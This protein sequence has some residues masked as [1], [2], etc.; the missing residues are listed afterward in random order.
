MD[1]GTLS[2][3]PK[4]GLRTQ[5]SRKLIIAKSPTNDSV[6]TQIDIKKELH[7]AIFRADVK[8][9]EHLFQIGGS[10]NTQID[11]SNQT[12]LH[13]ACYAGH[14]DVVQFL[15]QQ[16]NVNIDLQDQH[17]WTPLLCAASCGQVD[18]CL[19]LLQKG[20]NPQISNDQ[21]TTVLHYL[22]RKDLSNID[23][24]LD[25]NN[26]NPGSNPTTA[27]GNKYFLLMDTILKKGLDINVQNVFGETP[28][29]QAAAR[30]NV[31]A[32]KFLLEHRAKWNILTSKGETAL[33]YAE[34]AGFDDIVKLIQAEQE[35]KKK[36]S[37]VTHANIR[38]D[39]MADIMSIMKDKESGVLVK[40][41]QHFFVF[42]QDSFQG[43]DMVD[44]V[45][46]NLPIRTREEAV[47]YGQKLL[48]NHWIASVTRKKKFKDSKNLYQFSSGEAVPDEPK[49]EKVS[50]DDFEQVKVIGKGGFGKV[51]LARKIETGKIYAIKLMDKAKILN[52][53]RDFKN[54]MSEKRILQND[55]CFLVHLHYAFQNE[56]DFVLVMDFIGG[57]DLY[58][59][60][61]RL[62]RFPEKVVQ[63]IIAEL[64][65][66][67][68]YLHSC[69]IIYRDLKPQNILLDLDGHICLADFGLSKEVLQNADTALHTACG[70]PTYSAPE[71]LDGSPYK[72]TIDYWSLGIV[73]YQ[74]LVGKPPFEFDGDFAKLLNSIYS[75]EIY[76]PRP[77]ISENAQ[78]LLQ[79]F[80]QRDPH[81]R[82]DDPDIIK[83]HPFFRGIEW[84]KLEVKK[85]PS[86]I[87]FTLSDSDVSKNF[88]PKYTKMPIHEDKTN[89]K[90]VPNVPDFDVAFD[91]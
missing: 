27:I 7:S 41:R 23:D 80:L 75:D 62:K 46:K 77:Y 34:K 78:L 17:G 70:T 91:V 69:G 82:L 10:V 50:L 13:A 24:Q 1:N 73:M 2:S 25:L 71:V 21:K 26:N 65:I 12:P 89:R 53:P 90:P 5:K 35:K 31:A 74:F 72:K 6:E 83:R 84:E 28:L 56:T 33:I 61:K 44:W 40:D 64:V 52:K 87:K 79:E 88:D 48:D 14:L 30:G 47:V 59:H 67:L 86:P 36:K 15:L 43:S 3:S 60:L 55:C 39:N 45:L 29:M 18:I 76:Y 63:L 58:Y 19:L 42:H 38:L 49:Q 51:I 66:A 9:L 37:L 16:P 81:K 8:R 20:A 85:F 32:V 22:A 68:G 4:R 54:L 11:E 57:G